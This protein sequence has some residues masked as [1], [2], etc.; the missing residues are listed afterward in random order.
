MAN[1][2]PALSFVL[3]NE[4]RV[5]TTV[6][7]DPGGE[8]CWGISRVEWP[9]WL[10]W[11]DVDAGKT[12][13]AILESEV[14]AFYYINFWEFGGFVSQ[15]IATKTMDTCVLVGKSNGIKMLQSVIGGLTVDGVI[16]PKTTAAVNTQNETALFNH[17]VS[18]LCN[19]LRDIVNHNPSDL[20]FLAGWI[21]RA[22]KG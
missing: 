2:E 7:G 18:E 22:N 13:A 6:P 9:E 1:F 3:D 17:L 16:G 21:N 10:G 8:T 12:S 5:I 4:G 14:S 11:Q 19:Y 15:R 20:K